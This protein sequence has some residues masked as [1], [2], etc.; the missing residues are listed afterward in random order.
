[1]DFLMPRGWPENFSLDG[2][3]LWSRDGKGRHPAVRENLRVLS[4]QLQALRDELGVP[5]YVTN[6]HRSLDLNRSVGSND[7]SQHVIGRAADLR[8]KGVSTRKLH[9]T[10]LELIAD[11]R[12]LQGGV[13]LYVRSRFVHYDWRMT[14]ARW[15]GN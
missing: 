3:G 1:M 4:W 7:T 2:D 14:T 11:R 10:V 9:G 5:V 8:A 6:A 13:G 15:R 12:M